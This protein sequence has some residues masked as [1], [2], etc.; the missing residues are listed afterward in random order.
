MCLNALDT[1]VGRKTNQ[2][3]T[4]CGN[5]SSSLKFFAVFFSNHLEFYFEILQLYTLKPF[6]F[7]CQAKC[8]LFEKRQF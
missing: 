1:D 8:N 6:S 3:T 2:I 7:N 5:K 4:G